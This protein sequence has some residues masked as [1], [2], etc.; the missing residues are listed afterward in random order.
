MATGLGM[1]SSGRSVAG[2]SSVAVARAVLWTSTDS[3]GAGVAV[4]R[5]GLV[6]RSSWE[7]SDPQARR[8][9]KS[10]RTAVRVATLA[11]ALPGNLR[12]R[13]A[14]Q[15]PPCDSGERISGRSNGVPLR[16]RVSDRPGH[17]VFFSVGKACK[18]KHLRFVRPKV[19]KTVV[20]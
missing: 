3:V 13:V 11:V 4:S 9:S 12:L 19:R 1:R 2:H 10:K 7:S 16:A 8:V 18:E 17:D 5:G 20:R 15:P 6:R 14:S